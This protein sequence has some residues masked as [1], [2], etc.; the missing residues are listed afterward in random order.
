MASSSPE[1]SS[2]KPQGTSPAAEHVRRLHATCIAIGPSGLQPSGFPPNQAPL[3]GI[4]VRGPSGSGKSDLA[5]RLISQPLMF[6]VG[7]TGAPPEPWHGR[8]VADDQVLLRVANNRLLASAPATLSG[9]LE[10]RGLGILELAPVAEVAVSLVID[11]VSADRIDRLP[12]ENRTSMINDF[13][14]PNI[15]LFPYEA[16]APLKVALALI[17]IC[18][19]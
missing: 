8:L 10:V 11:L 3:H 5:L 19:I 18:N 17:R 4:L 15:E 1:Q 14:I 12:Q 7:L 2:T 16:S 9:K 6:P 13:S